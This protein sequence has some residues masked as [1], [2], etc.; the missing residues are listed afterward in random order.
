[1]SYSRG[2]QLIVVIGIMANLLLGQSVFAQSPSSKQ[3]EAIYEELL[4]NPAFKAADTAL[5]AI[6]R[7]RIKGASSVS[8]EKLKSAQK[9]WLNE[10]QVLLYNTKPSDRVL[11]AISLTQKRTLALQA[12]NNKK[13]YN[14]Q[15]PA[16]QDTLSPAPLN[17]SADNLSRESAGTKRTSAF[18][19][20]S[21]DSLLKKAESGDAQSQYKLGLVYDYGFNLV[22]IDETKAAFWYEKAANSGHIKAQAELGVYLSHQQTNAD[23]DLGLSWLNKAATQGDGHAMGA[24]AEAY[25]QGRGVPADPRLASDFYRGA[26]NALE[27]SVSEYGEENNID[28]FYIGHFFMTG[29]GTR[30]RNLEKAYEHL[31][32]AA[33][34]GNA[35]AQASLGHLHLVDDFFVH[36]DSKLA[37][38]WFRLSAAQ[39]NSSA[40]FGMGRCYFEGKG[41]P[42]DMTSATE[43]FQKAAERG[44]QNAQYNLGSI[45]YEGLGLPKDIVK[46]EKWFRKSAEFG[47]PGGQYGLAL[48]YSQGSVV[49][50]DTAK[51]EEWFQKAADQDFK[52]ALEALARTRGLD[53]S[54]KNAWREKLLKVV[55]DDSIGSI[56]G[57]KKEFIIQHFDSYL[58]GLS[59]QAGRYGLDVTQIL[60]RRADKL[61]AVS[62]L[63]DIPGG[64]ILFPVKL[65]VSFSKVS[66]TE[67]SD[68][69]TFWLDGFGDWRVKD[70]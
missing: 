26:F 42:K 16:T 52:P 6:Y 53:P 19:V 63:S 8:Q 64:T 18:H 9:Q 31:M 1:M 41:S 44:D 28:H 47:H 50:K 32:K 36:K 30:G 54:D 11:V 62:G 56:G 55:K 45:F 33:E 51:A 49:A 10:T 46:A 59:R 40:M 34:L 20:G 12:E 70:R 65:R 22:N 7:Q 24:L 69:S 67:E 5:N 29:R 4:R 17:Q 35:G 58:Q 68:V 14:S 39:G 15:K 60:I 23:V 37:P 43:W 3:S 57:P 21:F 13:D 38:T 66:A 48:M 2:P 25:L 61:S 27:K